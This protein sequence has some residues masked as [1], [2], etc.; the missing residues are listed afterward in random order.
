MFHVLTMDNVIDH[1][2]SKF[3]N[4]NQ[5]KKHIFSL[6]PDYLYEISL[7]STLVCVVRRF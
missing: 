4:C 1:V 2:I 5:I 6:F 3:M 7:H